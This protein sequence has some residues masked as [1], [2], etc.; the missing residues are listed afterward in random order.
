MKILVLLS[1][2][3]CFIL[4]ALATSSH[5]KRPLPNIEKIYAE[6]NVLYFDDKLPKDAVVDWGEPSDDY[7]ASVEVMS[8]GKFHVAF[9]DY[10]STAD[11]VARLI[12]LH[13]QCHI[14]TN[15][16]KDFVTSDGI[17][18]HDSHGKAWR[19]CMLG[20]DNQGAFRDILIDNYEEK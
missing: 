2:I 1:L 8:N 16:A 18:I 7:M 11:R 13:E 15:D 17:A 12:M 9:N 3:S 14:A 5:A 19:T 20:L 6:Y 4:G 10:F